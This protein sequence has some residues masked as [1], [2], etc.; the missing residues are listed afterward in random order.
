ML[1]HT[2][3][4]IAL[5]MRTLT[6]ASLKESCPHPESRVS[7]ALSHKRELLFST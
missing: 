4:E 6:K 2:L 3:Q 1:T 7:I 5:S